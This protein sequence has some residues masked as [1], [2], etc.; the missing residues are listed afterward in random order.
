MTFLIK[1]LLLT[2]TLATAASCQAT[3][4]VPFYGTSANG[5][6]AP[7]RGW[8]SF[9]LQAL[10]GSSAFV[11]NQSNVQAQCDLLN[12]TAGY[13]L[14][15]IDSG[16]SANG[17][18]PYGR[19]VPDTSV[20]PDLAGLADH[21][22]AQGMLLG[23]Y[24]LPGAFS[25]DASVTVEGTD[26]QLGSLFDPTQPSYNLR[27]T[28]DYSKDGV[29]QW[30]NSVVNNLAAMGVDM[31]K[32][33]YMTPGSPDAG[34][35]LPANNS[36]AAVA[37]HNAIQQ[38]GRS[39]RLDLSWKL[40]RDEGNDWQIWRTHA[41]ALRLDQDINNSGQST[42]VSFA[43]VQRAIEQYRIFI[44]QQEEDPTRQGIPIM[45]RPDMDNMYVG[46]PQSLTGLSDVERYTVAIHWVGAGANLITGSDL[47][48]IDALGQELLY[49]PEV[50][51]IA[52]FTANYPM[53]PKN[54]FNTADPG[55]QA[56]SQLQAW[57]AGPD[58]NN[59]NAVVVLANYGPDQGQGG[60]GTSLE[61]VQL[62][63]ISLADLGI[64]DGQPNGAPGW[65]VRRVLGGGG[66]GG[67]DHTD[68]GITSTFM[69]CNLGPGESALYK[70][71]AVSS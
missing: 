59:Q 4:S 28:F 20:F 16:W 55:S 31:I 12:A 37:Y 58:T 46:N 8:N 2:G 68:L 30:H 47:T 51:S 69:A 6:S 23:V 7:P 52:D 38:S 45:I 67:A 64:A 43:T 61:G 13:T 26:I 35:T 36:L 54:P 32:L 56:S 19:I 41:D 60:F 15:S 44:N 27:Q 5:F 49:D 66:S 48:Q 25:S 1:N 11:L 3:L 33:D 21:L 29:Q 24:I 34:E 70:L 57:I 17:G 62:V 14:C 10:G 18:D 9:G 63:N 39:I 40:D 71:T 42:L 65:N 22:H 50:L 53:Q